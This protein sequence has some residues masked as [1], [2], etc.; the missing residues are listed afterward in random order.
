MNREAA[1]PVE[2]LVEELAPQRR[3]ERYLEYRDSGVEWLGE[4][5]QHWVVR[6]LKHIAS[7]RTSNVDKKSHEE[8]QPVRLCNYTDVYYNE[9]IVADLTFMEATAS[10]DEIEKFSLMKG[11]VLI[12]K[13]S[14]DPNDIAVPACVVEDLDGV[15]CGYHLAQVRAHPSLGHGPYLARAFKASGIRDQFCCQATGITRHGLSKDT[16]GCS[17]FLVPPLDEQRAI[18][19]FLDRETARI[20]E[21]IVKKQR[22]IELLDEQRIALISRAVTTGLNPDAPCTD[23]GIPWLG[24]VPSHWRILRLR[25]VAT[26]GTQNGLHK[27]KDYYDNGGV[28]I[29]SMAE[30]FRAP[31][32][33]KT[34][35]DRLILT[36]GEF[37]SY[38]LAEGD[39]LF[40]RRSIVFEG[41][42]L[43]SMVGKLNEPHIFESSI[44]RVRPDSHMVRSPFAMYVLNSSFGRYQMLRITKRV[45]ISGI[46]GPG[47]KDSRILVPPLPEQD[48]ILAHITTANDQIANLTC[49]TSEAIGKL[50]EFRSALISAAVTGKID[51]RKETAP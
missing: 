43:C 41:S 15:L 6:K 10:P 49:K 30:A 19:A 21:L 13:D 46:D 40:A 17:Q 23:S 39:L 2:E 7:L 8:E 45:T 44:I 25:F 3:F 29:V 35:K 20:D 22:L 27:P 4:I 47:L 33:S 5:P 48:E 12:T 34:A 31:V 36:N 26:Q 32:I 18:A 9:Q 1:I 37:Q 16:I 42:G 24:K 14:E 38:V 11:D 51:V 50:R 28:P